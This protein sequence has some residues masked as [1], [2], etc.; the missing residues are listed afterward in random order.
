[1]QPLLNLQT[2][3]IRLITFSSFTELSSPL[4]KDLNVEKLSDVITLQL[5]VFMC[6]F[7]N[8]LLS[9]VF[10]PFFDPVRNTDSSNTRFPCKMTY[11]IPKATTNYGISNGRFQRTTVKNNISDEINSIFFLAFRCILQASSVVSLVLFL[12]LF[13]FCCCFFFFFCN[14]FYKIVINYHLV[15]MRV[16]DKFPRLLNC[17]IQI[18][19]S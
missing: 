8:Q 12:L 19:L 11:A 5:A 18:E 10:D 15:S 4:S 16:S 14:K 3:V 9:L 2:K 7:H 6:N 13:C 17:V 1:M